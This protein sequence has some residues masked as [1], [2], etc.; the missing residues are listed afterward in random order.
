MKAN[1]IPIRGGTDGS[2][3]SFEGIPT[4][5]IFTGGANFHGPYE[6]TVLESMAKAKDI[7]IDI[8]KMN[9]AK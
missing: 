1:I 6:Y 3:L 8:V 7:I 4:P 5:N 2:K 9:S